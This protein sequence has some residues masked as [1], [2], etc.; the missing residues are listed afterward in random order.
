[1]NFE[2]HLLDDLL[3][4]AL[5]RKNAEISGNLMNFTFKKMFWLSYHKHE[6]C[7]PL[8][9]QNKSVTSRSGRE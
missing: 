7:F 6:Q 5:K 2:L 4:S 1:M 8:I 3:I 9:S